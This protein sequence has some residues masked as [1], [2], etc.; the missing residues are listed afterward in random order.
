MLRIFL[1]NCRKNCHAHVFFCLH[2]PSVPLGRW[3][4]VTCARA[5]P[6]APSPSRRASVRSTRSPS[7]RQ[8]RCSTLPQGTPCACG[9][10]TGV[11][12][13]VG[14]RGEKKKKRLP[15]S[16][17][18]VSVC[19]LFPLTSGAFLKNPALSC[20]HPSAPQIFF[21]YAPAEK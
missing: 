2:S 16:D 7:T 17:V 14:C 15:V 19:D 5:P 12:P 20:S 18:N 13:S 21:S 11:C 8:G 10:S 1:A 3:C 4:Q 6:P 9:T